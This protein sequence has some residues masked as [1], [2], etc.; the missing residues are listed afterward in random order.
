M[1]LYWLAPWPSAAGAPSLAD[2][3]PLT[4]PLTHSVRAADISS[5]VDVTGVQA[6]TINQAKVVFIN[7]RPQVRRVLTHL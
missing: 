5:Y 1:Y 6:Y 3:Q 7:H 2:P 4:P